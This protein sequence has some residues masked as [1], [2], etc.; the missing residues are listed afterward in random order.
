MGW[1]WVNLPGLRSKHIH[2]CIY[3]R[4]WWWIIYARVGKRI[5]PWLE[6]KGLKTK[7]LEHLLIRAPAPGTSS[8]WGTTRRRVCKYVYVTKIKELNNT[9]DNDCLYLSFIFWWM[10]LRLGPWE[11][12]RHRVPRK[13]KL[14]ATYTPC[15][16]FSY[17]WMR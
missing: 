4:I 6:N 13:K 8:S 15:F 3:I 11:F 10:I 16:F 17:E 1:W 5:G 14:Q 2:V 7:G 12:F 9:L